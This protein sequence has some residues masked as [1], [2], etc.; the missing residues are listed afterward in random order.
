MT[1]VP[2]VHKELGE[3]KHVHR[4]T[5]RTGKQILSNVDTAVSGGHVHEVDGRITSTSRGSGHTHTVVADGVEV[6]S[7]PAAWP[8]EIGFHQE[9]VLEKGLMPDLVDP[10]HNYVFKTGEYGI[11]NFWYQ[12]MRGNY[13]RYSNAPKDHK[14]YDLRAG[15]PLMD[16]NQPLPHT[17]PQYFTLEGRR[18]STALPEEVESV[19]NAG[20]DPLNARN[21]W[22]E[23]YEDPTDG[24][25]RYIYLDSDIRENPDLWVQYQL[26]VVDAGLLQYRQF[27][28]YLFT[29]KQHPKD[30]I[31]G[32]IL[33]LVEQGLYEIEELADA[34]ISDIA[35][36]DETIKLLGRK[37]VCDIPFYD[38]LTSLVA[39]RN[40]SD[41]LF[42]VD[43]YHG[44]NSF[45][46]NYLFSVFKHMNMS[47]QHLM[48]W[49]ASQMFSRVMNRLAMASDVPPEE[50]EGRALS[51]LQRMFSTNENIKH[52]V[53]HKVRETLLSNYGVDLKKA[54][55]R[56]E[57]DDYGVLVVFSDLSDLRGDELAFSAWLHAEPM[58]DI[59]EAE[60][61]ALEAQLA[62]SQGGDEGGDEGDDEG[63]EDQDPAAP[64]KDGG[65]AGPGAMAVAKE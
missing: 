56:S 21:V 57:V 48:Y 44:Q 5:M 27:A 1:S 15:I 34:V 19:V 13:W 54:L 35:F 25:R 31:V 7:G 42:M 43:T 28:T 59:S 29:E 10:T 62:I 63:A 39:G 22:Y 26:R 11:H 58:H 36:I 24:T 32:A 55:S 14:D 4:F 18:R 45:G 40:P 16:K 30:R 20:Y 50:V 65:E 37:F 41:P 6:V 33:M 38:F 12:D 51:E 52:M 64:G 53:D 2:D 9:A 60:E 8:Q 49:R 47:P 61:I 46:Y 23:T 17:A 3:K